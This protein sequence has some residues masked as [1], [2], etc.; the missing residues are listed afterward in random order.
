[1]KRE[2][3]VNIIV[4]GCDEP[5][6]DCC[7]FPVLKAVEDAGVALNTEKCVFCL[8]KLVFLGHGLTSN[9]VWPTDENSGAVLDASPL[10]IV[11][12]IHSFLGLVQYCASFTLDLAMVAEPIQ[13]LTWKNTQFIC[14]AQQNATFKELKDGLMQARWHISI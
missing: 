13:S 14:G 6:H 8:T 1:M 10:M 7:L 12:E 2:G 11:S 5:E 3:V 9:G 4:H